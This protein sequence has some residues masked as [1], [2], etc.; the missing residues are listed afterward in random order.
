VGYE[1]RYTP[2]CRK[3]L[4]AI[5]QPHRRAVLE[6]IGQLATD[7]EKQGKPSMGPLR[8]HRSIHVSRF[9]VIYRVIRG[10]VEVIVLAAGMRKE[11]C[12]DDVYEL[13]RKLVR[14]FSG[15]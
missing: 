3:T 2:I 1:I 13:A 9:R 8:G 11:G 14:D 6:R 12:R 10:R 15:E 4:G 5:Q 7:P